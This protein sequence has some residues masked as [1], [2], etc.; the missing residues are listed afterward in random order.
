[1]DRGIE[2]EMEKIKAEDDLRTARMQAAGLRQMISCALC[3]LCGDEIADMEFD[4]D[5]AGHLCHAEC[6]T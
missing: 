2:A 5:E 3:A 6:V 4:L 1:M